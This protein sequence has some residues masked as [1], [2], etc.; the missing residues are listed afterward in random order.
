M[1]KCV[2]ILQSSYIPWKGYFDL[3]HDADELVFHDDV[4]YTVD[5][6]NRNRIKTPHG[7]QWLTIPVGTSPRRRICDVEL[8]ANGW[9][10]NHWRRIEASYARAPHFAMYRRSLEDMYLRMA[11]DRLADLNQLL[12]RTIARW[13]GITTTFRD[14][15]EFPLRA[16][17]QDRVLEILHHTGADAYVSGPAARAYLEP[18]RFAAAGIALRWKDY[19]GYPEYPQLHPPFVHEVSVLDLLFH[20]GKEA[21]SYIWGWR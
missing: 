21:P 5:W 15:R 16:K 17:K 8:P 6:R 9:A 19:G 10:R 20:T 11:F 7:V 1:P 13:L 4:Q 12:I 3:I 18:L 2:A 14:S